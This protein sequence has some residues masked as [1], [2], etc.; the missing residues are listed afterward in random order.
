MNS[1]AILIIYG[2]WDGVLFDIRIV[3]LS[4][5]RFSPTRRSGLPLDLCWGLRKDAKNYKLQ[6]G[7]WGSRKDAK[8]IL[9]I[10]F[11]LFDGVFEF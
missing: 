10:L 9:L 5:Y 4:Y 7:L 3:G 1:G 8:G 6:S 11:F 2:A